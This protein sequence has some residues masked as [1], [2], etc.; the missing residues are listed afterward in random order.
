MILVRVEQV[1]SVVLVV[2]FGRLLGEDSEE[3]RIAHSFFAALLAD[4]LGIARPNAVT[5]ASW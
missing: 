3:L 5:H 2:I 1:L 4:E